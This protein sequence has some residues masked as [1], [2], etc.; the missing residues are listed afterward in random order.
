MDQQGIEGQQPLKFAGPPLLFLI[1]TIIVN[2]KHRLQIS[3]SFL[4]IFFFIQYY[5][6]L[7]VV[8]I[9]QIYYLRPQFENTNLNYTQYIQTNKNFFYIY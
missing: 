6:I 5:Y 7:K 1:F 8:N 2:R 3:F 9:I 4:S